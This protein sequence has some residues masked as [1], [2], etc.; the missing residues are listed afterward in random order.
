[1][2]KSAVFGAKSEFRSRIELVG[3]R[4]SS[5]CSASEFVMSRSRSRHQFAFEASPKTTLPAV[6]EKSRRTARRIKFKRIGAHFDN[7]TDG[8]VSSS[9]S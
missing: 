2:R 6:F 7:L 8:S 9:A 5:G 1:M 4:S 3:V